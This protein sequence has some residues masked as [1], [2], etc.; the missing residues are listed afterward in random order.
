M[1]W[2]LLVAGCCLLIDESSRAHVALVAL[3]VFIFAAFYSP[4]EGPVPFTYSAEVFPLSHREVGMS[5]A[6]AT[7]SKPRVHHPFPSRA[8]SNNPS[9]SDFWGAILSIS[10]PRMLA[11]FTPTGVFGFYAGLNIVAFFLIFFFLYET[12]QRTLEELD[13]VFGVPTRTH[14]AFQGTK[15]FPWWFRRWVLMRKGEVEPELYHFDGAGSR[16]EYT[17]QQDGDGEK[18]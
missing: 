3:F 10:L 1:A 16:D 13:Y 15:Q 8:A 7:N 6:V 2:S 9:T 4:G 17:G 14:A 5:W 18:A 11:A 12:K